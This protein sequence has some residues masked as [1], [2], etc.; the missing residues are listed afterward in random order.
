MRKHELYY[1]AE[2]QGRIRSQPIY[3]ADSATSE[4]EDLGR[5]LD[6]VRWTLR[7]S[8]SDWAKTH[9]SQVEAHLLRRIKKINQGLE[10]V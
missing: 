7:C 10:L 3:F 1:E 6:Q 5:R 9:W 4:L 2:A 8:T